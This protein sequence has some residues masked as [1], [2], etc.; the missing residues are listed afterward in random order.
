MAP[1]VSGTYRTRHD[2]AM[3]PVTAPTQALKLGFRL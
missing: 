3:A 1:G 2:R